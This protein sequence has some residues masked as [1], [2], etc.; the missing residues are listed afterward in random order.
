ML[1]TC[2]RRRRLRRARQRLD[3]VESEV[4]DR[5]QLAVGDINRLANAIAEINDDIAL[6]GQ[7]SRPNDLLDQ[8][9]R[10]VTEL[11]GLITVN[12]VMQEDG[13]MNVFI[14]SGTGDDSN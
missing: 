14:G 3:E 1:T 2:R 5:L 13:A 11:S 10:L 12:T 4:N 7:G 6:A 8:R 9:D